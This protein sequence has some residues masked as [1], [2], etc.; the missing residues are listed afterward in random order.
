MNFRFPYADHFVERH[1]K[2][3]TEVIQFALCHGSCNQA[4]WLLVCF[5]WELNNGWELESNTPM[6]TIYSRN[7]LVKDSIVFLYWQL[8]I[9]VLRSYQLYCDHLFATEK[10]TS[11]I[12]NTTLSL[13]C[14]IL[15]VFFFVSLFVFVFVFGFQSD[16]LSFLLILIMLVK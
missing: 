12:V 7:V 11:E 4:K 8:C 9:F 1:E 2:T 3:T 6:S 5:H 16:E 13:Y 14:Q 10:Q 15:L